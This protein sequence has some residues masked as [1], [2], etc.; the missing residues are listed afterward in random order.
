M[1]LTFLLINI[2]LEGREGCIDVVKN[3]EVGVIES[4]SGDGWAMVKTNG[5]ICGYVPTSYLDIM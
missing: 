3:E 1:W 4:D 2:I 5:E